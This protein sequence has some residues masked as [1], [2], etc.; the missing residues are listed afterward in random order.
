MSPRSW[1]CSLSRNPVRHCSI[2]QRGQQPRA[3]IDVRWQVNTSSD[4]RMKLAVTAVSEWHYSHDRPGLVTFC[5]FG[6]EDAELYSIL[7]GL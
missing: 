3:T 2:H 7:L 6:E 4:A 5:G 1:H